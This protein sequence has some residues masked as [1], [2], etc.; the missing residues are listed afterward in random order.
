MQLLGFVILDLKCCLICFPPLAYIASWVL[1]SCTYVYL[2][3]GPFHFVILLSFCVNLK[4]LTRSRNEIWSDQC[5]SFLTTQLVAYSM[6]W[7]CRLVMSSWQKRQSCKRRFHKRWKG[8]RSSQSQ[9]TNKQQCSAWRGKSTMKAK[10]ARLEVSSYALIPRRKWSLIT[11]E[12]NNTKWDRC[13]WTNVST[14]LCF[15]QIRSLQILW[16]VNCCCSLPHWHQA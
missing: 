14:H 13:S 9:E 2:T 3:E 11:W 10:W 5:I 4:L 8:P 12:T 1:R 6:L 7:L 15:V 16:K